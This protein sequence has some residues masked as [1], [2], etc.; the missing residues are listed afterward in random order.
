MSVVAWVHLA[1]ALPRPAIYS[2][3]IAGFSAADTSGPGFW[4]SSHLNIVVL[5][6][7]LLQSI[8]FL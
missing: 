2:A 5:P 4:L 6:Q 7:N 1:T 3:A 8:T